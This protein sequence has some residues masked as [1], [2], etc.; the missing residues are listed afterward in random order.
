MNHRLVAAIGR[1]TKAVRANNLMGGM[2]RIQD[3]LSPRNLDQVQSTGP[4]PTTDDRI[5]SPVTN[6]LKGD[7]PPPSTLF[8]GRF[9]DGQPDRLDTCPPTAA[10]TAP[11]GAKDLKP[12]FGR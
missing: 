4:V 3:A 12:G 8:I 11:G 2:R 6:R 10:T 5:S 1:A 7:S 9:N